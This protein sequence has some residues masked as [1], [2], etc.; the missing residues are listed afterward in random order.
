[1]AT[2]LLTPAPPC[3]RRGGAIKALADRTNLKERTPNGATN[4]SKMTLAGDPSH[5]NLLRFSLTEDNFTDTTRAIR[6]SM[7]GCACRAAC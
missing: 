6:L 4:D 1:M 2:K 3:S 5:V 7:C